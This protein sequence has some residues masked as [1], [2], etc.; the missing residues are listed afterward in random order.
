MRAFL[1]AE[2]KYRLRGNYIGSIPGKI[3]FLG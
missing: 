3:K 1:V 2:K